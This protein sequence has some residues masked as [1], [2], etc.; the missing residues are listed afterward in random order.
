MNLQ[1]HGIVLRKKN[2]TRFVPLIIIYNFGLL[3]IRIH[4]QIRDLL[5]SDHKLTSSH[6]Y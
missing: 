6:C 1:L 2:N 3:T 4:T 5:I